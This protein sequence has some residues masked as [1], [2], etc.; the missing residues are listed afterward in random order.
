[1]RRASASLALAWW[2]VVAAAWADGPNLLPGD[3]SFEVGGSGFHLRTGLA[4][5]WSRRAAIRPDGAAEG[6]W[7]V[8]LAAGTEPVPPA[9]EV[10]WVRLAPGQPH[11]LSAWVRADRPGRRAAFDITNAGGRTQT[12]TFAVSADWRRYSAS[13]DSSEAAGGWHCFALRLGTDGA[14]PASGELWIDGLRLERGEATPYEPQAAIG[15]HPGTA[16][17]LRH[18]G[19]RVDFS[20]HLRTPGATAPVPVTWRL[21][22]PFG[23]LLR[24]SREVCTIDDDGYG[25]LAV[26]DKSLRPGAY[27]LVAAAE[28]GDQVLSGQATVLAV[29]PKLGDPDRWFGVEGADGA[30]GQ[31]ALDLLRIGLHRGVVG[32]R[33]DW[34]LSG[35]LRRRLEAYL[36]NGVEATGYLPPP[37]GTPA[38]YQRLVSEVVHRADGLVRC[39][40]PPGEATGATSEGQEAAWRRAAF[41]GVRRGDRGAR[42]LGVR[43]RAD[44]D[45]PPLSGLARVAAEGGLA[46]T[47]AVGLELGEGP[48]ELAGGTGLAGLLAAMPGLMRAGGPTK[49]I[50]VTAA[51]WPAEPWEAP[52]AL[53]TQTAQRVTPLLQASYLV[54]AVLL[55]RAGGASAFI[56]GGAPQADRAATL[57]VM[58]AGVSPDLYDYT[59]APL[60]AVAALDHVLDR[61]R[62]RTLDRA[63]A[64]GP[65]VVCQVWRGRR[66]MAT[67]WQ[68]RQPGQRFTW[69][70]PLP[71]GAV[72][73]MDMFGRAVGTRAAA[74]ETRIELGEHPVFVEYRP[75]HGAAFVSALQRSHVA[76]LPRF[77]VA[78]APQA[79]GLGAAVRNVSEV[80]LTGR[81]EV[82]IAGRPVAGTSFGPLSASQTECRPTIALQELPADQELAVT[83]RGEAGGEQ[84]TATGTVLWLPCGRQGGEP[85]WVSLR[86][87]SYG[88]AATDAVPPRFALH[89]DAAAL[90]LR[91]ETAAAP[92]AGDRLEVLVDPEPASHAFV[93]GA[94]G[95]ER[96]LVVQP[97]TGQVVVGASLLAEPL[98]IERAER[99]TRVR[100]RL[101]WRRLGRQPT[102]GQ[103]LGFDLAVSETAADGGTL[104]ERRW[105]GALPTRREPRYLGWLRLE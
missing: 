65:G 15:V 95:D 45:E 17:R 18:A 99:A 96:R 76:G 78:V 56:Y 42:L 91:V 97:S 89:W 64:L 2:L 105:R 54:R 61:L 34:H 67:V 87:L 51:G 70:V 92:A 77:E 101:D 81:C 71:P 24:G 59:G 66:P 48:P 37:G 79:D 19:E 3:T 29:V 60:P 49:P 50:V 30:T 32:P 83:V 4:G 72:L 102:A 73:V 38:E 28:F 63:V 36:R 57:T 90:E 35:A 98:A 80:S 103:I 39:W 16:R 7:C 31:T 75:G 88:S 55:A 11:A 27:R 82:H 8:R 43:L 13:F 22:D 44:G 25:E 58:A 53:P 68:V 46:S 9:L 85:R 84:Q 40:E 12:T 33:G 52:G 23:T 104:R 74:A 20:I 93:A 69:A 14:A 47:D 26:V 1:M 94:S 86:R 5:G 6:R 41:D 10:P 100:C 62:G 21:E